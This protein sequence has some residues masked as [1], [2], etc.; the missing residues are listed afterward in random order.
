M[1]LRITGPSSL[2][3]YSPQ[4]RADGM[5]TRPL[6]VPKFVPLDR[7]PPEGSPIHHP[8]GGEEVRPGV[9]TD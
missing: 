1:L 9:I 6:I 8:V 5:R 2:P 3:P 7:A 4:K